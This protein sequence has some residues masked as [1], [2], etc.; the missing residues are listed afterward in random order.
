MI[1]STY[2]APYFPGERQRKKTSH[3]LLH[4]V[5]LPE[6]P[7]YTVSNFTRQFSEIT[8]GNELMCL[9]MDCT[10]KCI[11]MHCA[12]MYVLSKR[13]SQCFACLCVLEREFW[14][15]V[16]PSLTRI[17]T[18]LKKRFPLHFFCKEFGRLHITIIHENL[19]LHVVMWWDYQ[20]ITL[21]LKNAINSPREEQD[22]SE[23]ITLGRNKF[24][25]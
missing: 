8:V 23:K 14:Q 21:I 5:Y 9:K 1:W 10:C 3:Y 12:F 20:K 24:K 25:S 13:C 18:Y 7:S 15:S 6:C 4:F 11:P 22:N 2:T 16:L 19:F 17:C